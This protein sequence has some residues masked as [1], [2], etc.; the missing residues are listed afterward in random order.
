MGLAFDHCVIRY[1]LPCKKTARVV[2]IF[3]F[4]ENYAA[5]P[6]SSANLEYGAY[7]LLYE[8]NYAPLTGAR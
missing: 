6:Q 2:S 5:T 1:S 7:N 4:F 8:M 3:I